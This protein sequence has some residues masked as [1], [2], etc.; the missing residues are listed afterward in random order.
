VE[1]AMSPRVTLILLVVLI[2]LG[3]YVY[4]FELQRSDQR[5]S[6]EVTGNSVQI[7]DT[8]YGEYDIV[9]L[10]ILGPATAAHF[11]RTKETLTQD[12]E[13]LLPTPMSPKQLDQAR[14]NGAATRMG[15]LTA[16]QV[17]TG[18]TNLAQFG[19]EPP[20]LTV[21]LT[22][23]NGKR[24]TFYT[25]D[26]TPVNDNRYIRRASGD[27]SVFLVPA[28]AVDELRRLLDEVPLAPTLLPTLTATASF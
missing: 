16:N 24:I 22:I 11:V 19:L 18:V 3:G 26:E 9:E 4:L 20:E 14:V 28:L 12:W 15:R 25:G 6:D 23:S 7:Y 21:S 8:A 5:G 10:E 13:M 17:I 2:V 27:N 1:T